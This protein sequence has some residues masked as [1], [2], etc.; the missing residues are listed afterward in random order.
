MRDRRESP[1]FIQYRT[2]WKMGDDSA[3][4]LITGTYHRKLSMYF[5]FHSSI[6]VR[7]TRESPV[8]DYVNF[9]ST[10]C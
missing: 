6:Q 9:L 10:H 2:D 4:V 8:F 7:D 3:R 5:T 1:A